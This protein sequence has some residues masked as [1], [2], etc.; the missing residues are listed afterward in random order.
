MFSEDFVEIIYWTDGDWCYLE[1]YDG[2]P[3][4]IPPDDF[5][6]I[7]SVPCDLLETSIDQFVRGQLKYAFGG[8]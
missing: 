6:E 8:C 4:C 5:A 2:N 1:D 3:F 7:A